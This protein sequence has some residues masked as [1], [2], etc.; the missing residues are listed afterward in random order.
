MTEWEFFVLVLT[1]LLMACWLFFHWRSLKKDIPQRYSSRKAP[2]KQLVFW[3]LV[4]IW[5][6]AV[7]SFCYIDYTR[8]ISAALVGMRLIAVWSLCFFAINLWH[9]RVN[10]GS[11]QVRSN[12]EVP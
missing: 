3:A 11:Q 6:V 4:G 1:N 10:K 7:W 5:S 9:R 8:S 12:A 2:G